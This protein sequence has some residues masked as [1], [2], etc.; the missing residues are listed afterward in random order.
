MVE[1]VK[2]PDL[3]SGGCGFNPRWCHQSK[4]EHAYNCVLFLIEKV[5]DVQKD[6]TNSAFQV[7]TFNAQ[8]KWLT[9][10]CGDI[11]N[12]VIQHLGRDIFDVATIHSGI[13]GTR[14]TYTCD[15]N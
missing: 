3:H 9:A 11:G 4:K 10:G 1:L 13:V 14:R 15:L 5:E 7:V 12:M 2:I 6:Y 8:R